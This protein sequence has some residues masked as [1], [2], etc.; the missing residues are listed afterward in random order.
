MSFRPISRR[1]VLRT[2]GVVAL[3]GVGGPALLTACSDQS[4]PGGS[5]ANTNAPTSTAASASGTAGGAATGT[6][7]STGGS[8]SGA[9]S[10]GG[11]AGGTLNFGIHA[12][13]TGLDPQIG[14]N[15]STRW[16][17][18]LVY[19]YLVSLDKDN[20]LVPDLAEK[21]EQ[22][23]DTVYVFHLRKG[24][25]FHN[26]REMTSADV[27][28]SYDRIMDP[29]NKANFASLF[30]GISAIDLPDD[31]T[32]KITLKAPDASFLIHLSSTG[33]QAIVPKEVVEAN[34]GSLSQ[35]MV[36]TGPYKFV[37][38]TPGTSLVLQRN[39]DYFLAG[40]PLLDSVVVKPIED[41]SARINALKSGDVDMISFVPPSQI[42]SLGSTNGLVVS[43]G[44]VG[45]FYFLSFQVGRAPFNDV[46]VRQ[47]IMYAIDRQAMLNTAIFGQADLTP[48]GPI[49]SWDRFAPSQQVYDK[50][51]IAKAKSL[52]ADAG[53]PNGFETTI[54]VWT[55]QAYIVNAVQILQQQLAAIGVKVSIQ[56]FGDYP[57]Y[58]TTVLNQGKTDMTVTG[59]SGNIDPDDWLGNAFRSTGGN[60]FWHYNDPKVD[61][62]LDQ[63]KKEQDF[64]ARKKI[65][66]QL[67]YLLA[68]TGPMAFLWSPKQPNAWASKVT[69]FAQKPTGLLT[70]LAV[71]SIS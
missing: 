41:D 69:G 14:A 57:S 11:K 40:Q 7:S 37:S 59:F 58:Q 49:P 42:K 15:Q 25:K 36:G 66:D 21:W 35:V 24:V 62:L 43:E 61:Q 1:D 9:A 50:P 10:S 19:S 6:G 2:L 3:A 12:A 20:Q 16:V 29:A 38:Y 22:P 47:A 33:T 64:A 52:L 54:G 48:N 18:S 45:T 27:K 44:R 55:P 51:D 34:K 31:Y 46:R 13:L 53:H 70:N 67:Q 68:T 23:S 5:S 71:T 28:Y 32:V 4:S 60:N 39:P 26:G 56:Q 63:G 65:Y 8:T 30:G 17:A